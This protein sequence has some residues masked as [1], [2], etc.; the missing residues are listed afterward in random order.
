MVSVSLDE[1]T[2]AHEI[3]AIA[4]LF[5]AHLTDDSIAGIPETWRRNDVFMSQPAFHAH[6]SET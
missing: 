1:T 2:Q 4:A 3:E 6:R 5:A